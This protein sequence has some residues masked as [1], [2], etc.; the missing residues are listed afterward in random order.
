MKPESKKR[1]VVIGGV[2]ALVLFVLVVVY[3]VQNAPRKGVDFMPQHV[4][5]Q[6]ISGSAR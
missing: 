2:V 5:G 3:K 4:K 6:S 1:W